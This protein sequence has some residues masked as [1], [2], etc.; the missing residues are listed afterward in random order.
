MN[1]FYI[2]KK[3]VAVLIGCLSALFSF[4][5]NPLSAQGTA[6]NALFCNNTTYGVTQNNVPLS[7]LTFEAYIKVNTYTNWDGIVS[8]DDNNGTAIQLSILNGHLNAEV[9]FAGIRRNVE[10]RSYILDNNFHHVAVTLSSNILKLYVDGMEEQYYS[11]A[12]GNLTGFNITQKLKVGNERQLNGVFNGTIDEVRIWDYARTQAQLQANMNGTIPVNSAGLVGYYQ[13]N[14]STAAT[15]SADSSPSINPLDIYNSTARDVSYAM[16]AP[17]SIAATSV[18]TNGFTANWSAALTGTYTDVK[19]DVS[20]DPGFNSYLTGYQSLSVGTS[21]TSYIITGLNPGINYY[22]RLRAYNGTENCYSAKILVTTTSTTNNALSLDGVDDYVDAGTVLPA[23]SS[24]T[25]EAWI[26]P[27][28]NG[29]NNIISSGNDP[30]YLTGGKLSAGN[31]GTYNNVTSTST[32]PLNTWTHVAVTYNSSG[33]MTLYINGLL[34]TTG[35]AGS[36]SGQAIYIGRH[37]GGC[38]FMGQMDNVRIWNVERTQAEIQASMYCLSSTTGL[39]AN[40]TF[41]EGTANSNNVGITTLSDLSGNNN[42]GT[43]YNFAL[44]G[45]SSNFISEAFNS[46]NITSSGNLGC[47]GATVTFTCN[48]PLSG[49]GATY[50]WNKNGTP[51]AGANTSTYSTSTLV[52]GDVITCTVTPTISCYSPVTSNAITINGPAAE[53][54][55]NTSDN[56]CPNTS[57]TLTA[58]RRDVLSF[59]GGN[60]A[61]FTNNRPHE[62]NQASFTIETWINTYNLTQGIFGISDGDPSW[63]QGEKVVYLDASGHVTFVG[64]WNGYINSG[65]DALNDGQ[66]HHIAVVWNYTG[67]TSGSGLIY[68]D[69]VDRTT[70]SSYTANFNGIGTFSVGAPNYGEAPNFFNGKMQELRVWNTARTQAQIQANMFQTISTDPLL[71]AYYRLQD[72]SGNTPVDQTGAGILTTTNTSW[73]DYPAPLNNSNTYSWSTGATTASINVLPAATTTYSVTVTSSCGTSNATKTITV[74]PGATI[75]T[76]PLSVTKCESDTATFTI[77]AT[78]SPL[79]YQWQESTNGTTYN[80]LSNTALYD[81]VTTSILKVRGVTGTMQGYKYR[82]IVTGSSSCSSVISNGVTL[83]LNSGITA[84]PTNQ[85]GCDGS[86]VTFSLTTYSAGVTYQWQENTGS[87]FTNITN[88]G[89][90]SGA[91]SSS[92]SLSSVIQSMNG[93]Q[94]RCLITAPGCNTPTI[95]SSVTLTVYNPTVIV[96]APSNLTIYNG[97]NAVFTV[98]ATGS[99]LTYQ[100]QYSTTGGSSWVN[101]MTTPTLTITNPATGFNNALFK[102]TVT[103]SCGSITTTPVTLSIVAAKILSFTPLAANVGETVTITGA[104]FSTTASDNIVFFGPT[105]AIVNAATSTTLTVT[106]PD[107]ATASPISVGIAG[108]TQ[109]V[110]SPLL[111]TPKYN[112]GEASFTS[113]TFDGGSSAATNNVALQS[114]LKDINGDGKAELITLAN[115]SSTLDIYSIANNAGVTTITYQSSVVLSGVPKAFVLED[116]NGDSKPDLILATPTNVQILRNTSTTTTYSFTSSQVISISNIAT[117]VVGDLSIDGRPDILF[118]NTTGS[119]VYV[120]RNISTTNI[121]F[122]GPSIFTTSGAVI[123]NLAIADIDNDGKND[124]VAASSGSVSSSWLTMVWRNTSAGLGPVTMASVVTTP[125]TTKPTSLALADIDKDGKTDFILG[126]TGTT[127]TVC[128]NNSTSGSIGFGTKQSYTTGTNPT[129]L[130]LGDIDGDGKVD[131]AVNNAGTPPSLSLLRNTSTAGSLTAASFQT[132]VNYSVPEKST[133]ILADITSDGKPE[134]LAVKN[135]TSGLLHFK[136][137]STYATSV[138]PSSSTFCIGDT[139]ILTSGNQTG[140]TYSWSDGG[141]NS[142]IVN[143]AGTATIKVKSAVDK[144]ITLTQT[145]PTGCVVTATSALTANQILVTLDPTSQTVSPGATVTFTTAASGAGSLSYTWQENRGAGFLTLAD[146]SVYSSTNTA[147]LTLSGVPN[148]MNGYTYRCIVSGGCPNDTSAIAT[149]SI[150]SLT[151]SSTHTDVSCAGGTNG[152][153][154]VTVTGGTTPYTY[155]WGIFGLSGPSVTGLAAGTYTVVI[156]DANSTS[157]SETIIINESTA[158]SASTSQTAVTCNGGS[159]GSASVSVSGGTGAYTYS[160][161]PNTSTTSSASGLT[162]GSYSV[163]IT[164]AKGCSLVKTLNVS[165]PAAIAITTTPTN[166]SCNGGSNGSISASVTGGTGSYTYSW[167]TSTSTTSTASGL[168]AGSH[169]LYVTDAN[170]CSNTATVVLSQPAAIVTTGSSTNV[171]CNGGVNGTATVSVTGGTGSYTYAW[172]PNV[173]TTAAVTALTAGTYTVNV[174]DA[175]GCSA[176]RSF[177]VTQ[178]SALATTGIQTN[179][180]CNGGSNGTATV[181]V[182]GGTGSYSYSWSPSGGTAATATGLAAGN[183]TVNITDANGCSTTKPY[184]I[185]QP[186]VLAATGTQTN[187]SCNGG[188]NGIATAFITGGTSPYTY[189]WSPAGGTA[190]TASGLAAGTYTVSISDANGC[191]TSNSYIIT[192]PAG[193]SASMTQTN[194]SCN[195]GSNGSAIVTVTGGTGSYAY[196]WTPSGGGAATATGL[197]AGNYTVTII[198][199]NACT[200][201]STVTITEPAALVATGSQTNISCNGGS[202]GSATVNVTGGTGTYSYS[203]SPVTASTATVT[204]LTPGSYLVIVTDANGCTT[205]K[206]YTLTQPTALSVTGTQ[207][208]VSCNAGADGS[209]T[210]SVTGGTGSYTYSWS[211]TGG[212]NATATALSAGTYTVNIADANNCSTSQ[213]FIITEPNALAVSLA[214]TNE[215]CQNSNGTATATATGGTGSYSYLWSPSGSTVLNPGGLSAGTHFVTV[216]DANGC[217]TSGSVTLTTTLPSSS[218]LSAAI[219]DGNTYSFGTQNLTT[220]GTYTRTL[221]NAAG[222]DSVITLTLT[223][224]QPSAS[225]ETAT[226]CDGSSYIFGTQTLTTAGTYTRTLTNTVGCDSVIT[227]TLNVNQ[228]TASSSNA[229]ICNGSSYTFGTQTLTTAGTYTETLTNAAGC[230]SVITLVLNVNQPT[231]STENATICDGSS[232]TFGSQTLT[233]AGTYTRTLTNAA[234]CDS[235]ITLTLIVNQP[236]SSAINASICDGTSYT[237]GSQTLT[238]AGVYTQTLTNAAGCDS[239]VTLTLNV[240]QPSSSSASAAICDGSTYTF[241]TQNLTT[242]GTYTETFVNASGCDSVVTLTLSVNMPSSSSQTASICNGSSYIFGSQTLTAAGVY[243]ETVMNTAGC[244]SVITLTLDLITLDATVNA[245]NDTLKA[246]GVNVTY[247]WLYCDSNN[248]PIPGATAQQYIATVSGNY[249]VVVSDGTC[250]ETSACIPVIVTGAIEAGLNKMKLYPNPANGIITIE[251]RSGN[252]I[253]I[254]NAIGELVYYSQLSSDVSRINLNAMA[255]GVYMVKIYDQKIVNTVRLVIE[256]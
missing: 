31:A 196:S 192:E 147:S 47:A 207:T 80:N 225:T 93:F 108:S 125:L 155:S 54:N 50:Q 151:A 8:A 100:W 120:M 146:S 208:N 189:S 22:Y 72:G 250:S 67:G 186:A 175:N 66:W 199:A 88:G 117:F 74:L 132:A 34:V 70:G 139:V 115:T 179:V 102:V 134:M 172:I 194:V 32:I 91:T 220:A 167:T 241:G 94:Y 185:Y 150:T 253:E 240:G 236:T 135:V 81:G 201:T 90:Y 216:T 39:L 48:A 206:S 89:I 178:P 52:N 75:T 84:Q 15:T 103:G 24:Y 239:T 12:N 190:A 7:S 256:R 212:T 20:T 227:L 136:N 25:K 149:L 200:T 18:S 252:M 107:G 177:I 73:I 187:V 176:S 53:I 104:N 30:L 118:A 10:G 82:C 27:Y 233:T 123:T 231:S 114:V 152:T 42:N 219:C 41:N 126:S 229:A 113:N 110:S 226:I 16:S 131:I 205:S 145:S 214:S 4:I 96:T 35:S 158:L 165:Q 128:L 248:A 180:S 124:I 92:L 68:V 5:S 71:V 36:Y 29:C 153:A 221:T 245:Q 211:P 17:V 222:C 111:F 191:T 244:D 87:G 43:L 109:L 156:T 237:F 249:A 224:N 202:D 1:P 232:Y 83:N 163:T 61:G 98:A 164:D 142:T 154:D 144:T 86:S 242:A 215:A 59:N 161:S 3:D 255:Q 106:V 14:E 79:T 171:S 112:C 243:T 168:T 9:F 56:V 85:S 46:A 137:L 127:V 218:A 78:G 182:T 26:Y 121:S 130:S 6:S 247:Q 197:A 101:T 51:I 140:S 44:T 62:L 148:A 209:A 169:T 170:G 174:S 251:N 19:L 173:G 65:G 105:A 160:W 217:Q 28:A 166:I 11:D 204:G 157:T 238:T 97:Q 76:Q 193:L 69:G 230:D 55:A 143:G 122:S 254:Y 138:S 38:Y 228:P 37:T 234:G 223:V 99:N 57:I 45:Y 33:A 21:A 246:N 23:G 198:D 64:N 181:S 133:V 49:S 13:F 77:G 129:S 188:S 40:Y 235:V 116:L 60:S 95:S 210:V 119:G 58:G 2:K 213:T 203:W 162:A 195:A 159:N 184:T 63:E 183:Y 141:T